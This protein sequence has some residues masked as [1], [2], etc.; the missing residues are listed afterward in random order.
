MSVAPTLGVFRSS[1]HHQLHSEGEAD[2]VSS[3]LLQQ[4]ACALWVMEEWAQHPRKHPHLRH[5]QKGKLQCP[6]QRQGGR[7]WVGNEGHRGRLAGALW[8]GTQRSEPGQ[9]DPPVP[10]SLASPLGLEEGL[11]AER[12]GL[13]CAVCS[14]VGCG[15]NRAAGKRLCAL[16]LGCGACRITRVRSTNLTCSAWAVKEPGVPGAMIYTLIT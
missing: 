10:A 8:G 7:G 12:Q 9:T 15:F 6:K 13:C 2:W 3:A 5:K 11:C 14:P 1:S 4:V 16:A